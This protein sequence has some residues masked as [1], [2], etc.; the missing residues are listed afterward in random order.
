M[1]AQ[2]STSDV[3]VLLESEFTELDFDYLSKII[4]I[5]IMVN[6]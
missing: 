6:L 4:M 1:Q 5:W 2:R 3:L